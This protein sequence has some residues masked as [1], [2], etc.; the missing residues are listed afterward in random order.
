MFGSDIV[1]III[2]LVFVY[3]LMSLICTTF[4][5]WISRIFAMRSTNLKEGIEK[6][7][8]GKD[9]INDIYDHPL[10]KGL[11]PKEGLGEKIS[12]LFGH[13]P[14]PFPSNLPA[15]TFSL[16]LIDTL[17]KA[18]KA[19]GSGQWSLEVQSQQAIKSLEGSIESLPEDIK[20]VLGAFLKSAKTRAD[21]CDKAIAEFR[22]SIEQWFDDFTD[23]VS[24]WYKRKTQLI[25]LVSA[26]VFCFAL[27]VDTFVIAHTLY[28][29]TTLRESVVAAAEARVQQPAAT[30]NV[31]EIDIS[32]IQKDL[33]GLK[34]PIGWSGEKGTPTSLPDSPGGW[35]IKILGVAFTALAVSLGASF[36]Y[37]LLNKIVNL[38][39]AGKTPDKTEEK[40]ITLDT[41]KK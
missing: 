33:S 24:G 27:N 28:Q 14:R 30:E 2:G 20:K 21:K 16:V 5:E 29:D 22:T 26:F 17:M 35:A 6:L 34:L 8:N 13:S 19:G 4:T 39:A 10:I 38:R 3:F 25:V 37:D 9:L 11:A 31:S 36:W 1:E 15:R 23:R 12:R 41:A 32:K 18:G 40:T 7:V